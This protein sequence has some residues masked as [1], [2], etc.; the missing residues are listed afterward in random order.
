MI[1]GVKRLFI[2]N[3]ITYVSKIDQVVSKLIIDR[4]YDIPEWVY[5]YVN[6]GVL[7]LIINY[8]KNNLTDNIKL[9]KNND[10]FK[11]FFD[12]VK[13]KM[14]FSDKFIMHLIVDNTCNSN[15]LFLILNEYEI[16]SLFKSIS[17]LKIFDKSNIKNIY[18]FKSMIHNISNLLMN[19][20]LEDTCS[21]FLKYIPTDKIN[22]LT[23]SLKYMN[24][25]YYDKIAIHETIDKIKDILNVKESY[26]LCEDCLNNGI[27]AINK[28]MDRPEVYQYLQSININKWYGI[29]DTEIVNII[30]KDD[31]EM[32]DLLYEIAETVNKEAYVIIR[33]IIGENTLL[34]DKFINDNNVVSKPIKDFGSI[35]K[36]FSHKNYRFGIPIQIQKDFFTRGDIKTLFNNDGILRD[37]ASIIRDSSDILFVIRSCSKDDLRF[38]LYNSANFVINVLSEIHTLPTTSIYDILNALLDDPINEELWYKINDKCP[39]W[40]NRRKQHDSFESRQLDYRAFIIS[41]IELHLSREVMFDLMPKSLMYMEPSVLYVTR[42]HNSSN[43]KYIPVNKLVPY[44]RGIISSKNYFRFNL[45]CKG[46]L[47]SINSVIDTDT[48]IKEIKDNRNYGYICDMKDVDYESLIE[49]LANDL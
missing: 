19:D 37:E 20:I 41:R 27:P 42:H 24:E 45:F 36:I 10:A 14:D 22:I 29:I 8:Q 5:E 32:I 33:E 12:Y 16:K 28:Y 39:V 44:I 3:G 31:T 34:T 25:K 18:E 30:D 47:A 35:T 26:D 17:L 4:Q 15:I 21:E 1:K 7:T 49:L 40:L 38:L 46:E 43:T 6:E 2:N 9:Y 11:N 48:I 23:E 13:H